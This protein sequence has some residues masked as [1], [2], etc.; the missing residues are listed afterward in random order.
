VILQGSSLDLANMYDMA[1]KQLGCE[2]QSA[3]TCEGSEC[4]LSE[5]NIQ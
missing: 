4:G 1:R 3:G 2:R 5:S